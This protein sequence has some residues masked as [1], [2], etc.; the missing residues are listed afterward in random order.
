MGRRMT[1]GQSKAARALLGWSQGDLASKAKVAERT[2]AGFERG[3][4]TIHENSLD[5]LRRAY[6]A[7]GITMLEEARGIGVLLKASPPKKARK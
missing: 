4:R 6:E 1:P 7:A 2:V 5:S 3:E